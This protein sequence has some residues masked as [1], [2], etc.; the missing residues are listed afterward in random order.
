MRDALVPNTA[1]TSRKSSPAKVGCWSVRI[2]SGIPNRT[3]TLYWRADAKVLAVTSRTGITSGH[4]VNWSTKVVIYRAPED[5]SFRGPIQSQQTR[6]NGAP[7]LCGCSGALDGWEFRRCWHI[8]HNSK[9]TAWRQRSISANKISAGCRLASYFAWS[10]PSVLGSGPLIV[11]PV[12]VS[13][14]Q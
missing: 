8:V 12:A 11:S 13:A 6:W 5:A 9:A 3:N 2:S 10:E 4:F 7:N 1:I 14:G